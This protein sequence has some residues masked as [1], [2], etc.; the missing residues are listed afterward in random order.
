MNLITITA[1]IAF[2]IARLVMPAESVIHHE[3][4]FKDFAHLFVGGLFGAGLVG[5]RSHSYYVDRGTRIRYWLAR[6]NWR[7]IALAVA[8]TVLEVVAFIMHKHH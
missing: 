3:D 8:M 4:I 5:E 7:Y 6:R 2:G 1:C